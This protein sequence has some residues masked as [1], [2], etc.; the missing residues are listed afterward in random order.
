[1][2]RQTILQSAVAFLADPAQSGC[3]NGQSLSVDGGWANDG[4]WESL[5]LKKR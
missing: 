4:S 2:P 1:M 3:V 5:R